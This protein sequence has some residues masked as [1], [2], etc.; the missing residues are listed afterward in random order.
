MKGII[1]KLTGFVLLAGFL[2]GL[3]VVVFAPIEMF[4]KAKVETWP[5]RKGV[6]TLSYASRI[7]GSA[8]RSVTAAYWKAEICGRYIDDGEKFCIS[9]VRFGGFRFGEGKASAFETV[10]RY[11]IGRQVDIY[12][13]PE[14]PKETVL[15]AH[16]SWNE[17]LILLGLGIA[18][19]LLPVVL[20]ALRN[21]IE[22]QRYDRA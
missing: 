11:P 2:F 16:S 12:Y 9:R 6:I 19:L 13:S 1:G 8:A 18:F 15:E 4:K 7:P 3:F 5:S 22:P 14:N 20:W 10:G 21:K 17:M